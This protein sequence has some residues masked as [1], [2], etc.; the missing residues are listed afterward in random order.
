MSLRVEN[1]N[2]KKNY[3]GILHAKTMIMRHAIVVDYR[4][5]LTMMGLSSE[6]TSIFAFSPTKV[7]TLQ[8]GLNL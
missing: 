3:S 8:P 5:I 2:A 6:Y 1:A 4:L 7:E